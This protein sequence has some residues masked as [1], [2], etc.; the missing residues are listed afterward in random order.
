MAPPRKEREK[1]KDG[2]DDASASNGAPTT[3]VGAVVPQA[4][5]REA[6]EVLEN[7]RDAVSFLFLRESF[8]CQW[9]K[10]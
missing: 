10:R 2:N 3:T 9:E 6:L 4:L 1:A 8:P 7:K 5:P